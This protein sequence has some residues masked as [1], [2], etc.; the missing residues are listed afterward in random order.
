MKGYCCAA[1]AAYGELDASEGRRLRKRPEPKEAPPP[2]KASPVTLIYKH[3][4]FDSAAA[5]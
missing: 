3:A 1:R 5:A 4:K 2:K